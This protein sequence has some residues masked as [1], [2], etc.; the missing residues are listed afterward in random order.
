MHAYERDL[1]WTIL[2]ETED[3]ALDEAVDA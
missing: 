2:H 1:Q 3:G